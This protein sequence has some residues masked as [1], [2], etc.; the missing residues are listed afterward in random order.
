MRIEI[1]LRFNLEQNKK[2][3]LMPDFLF[4]FHHPNNQLIRFLF[5]HRPL[6]LLLDNVG[7]LPSPP[8]GIQDRHNA[9]YIHAGGL[10]YH[11]AGAIVSQL[12]KEGLMD[13]VDIPQLETFDAAQ[14]Q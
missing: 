9:K 3:G 4:I 10:R 8:K 12:K 1:L 5:V 6:C 14:P 13:A 2:S 7:W 11:G